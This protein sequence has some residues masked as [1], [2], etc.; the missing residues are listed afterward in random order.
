MK[1]TVEKVLE[2][3]APFAAIGIAIVLVISVLI[4]FS[5]IFLWGL[6]VGALV[7]VAAIVKRYFSTKNTNP[8][9]VKSKSKIIEHEKD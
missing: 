4:I 5:Y 3:F 9:V 6:I 1:N 7:W 8:K 2:K